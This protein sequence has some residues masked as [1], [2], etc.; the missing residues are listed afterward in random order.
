MAFFIGQWMFGFATICLLELLAPFVDLSFGSQYVFGPGVTLVLCLNFYFTGM[1]QAT[2]VF[3][4]SLGLFWYD[5]Y[6]SLVEAIINLVVSIILGY[7]FG[8]AG[9]FIGTLCSTVTTSLWVEPHMLYK[10]RLQAPVSVYFLKYAMYFGVTG[11]VWWLTDL[12]C[13]QVQGGVFGQF[14][15]RLLICLIVPNVM[16]LLVYGRSKEFVFVIRK[17]KRI[18]KSW[19]KRSNGKKGTAVSFS[20]EELAL[21]QIIRNSL[22][23]NSLDKTKLVLEEKEWDAV[24]RYAEKHGMVSLLYSELF[25][26]ADLSESLK[27]RVSKV[28]KQTV[29]QQ[30]RLLFLSKHLTDLLEENHICSVILKGVTVGTYYPVPELRKSGDVDLLLM[31][32]ADMEAAKKIFKENG[33]KVK[34]EQPSLHHICFSTLEGIEIELHTMLAEP[35]DNEKT[36]MALQELLKEA[37]GKVIKK[38]VMGVELPVLPDAYY[39]FD[40]LIHMLQHF[41]RSGFGLRLLCDWVMFWQKPMEKKDRKKY[42]ELV[43][44]IGIRGFSD[45]ITLTCVRFLGLQENLVHWMD[46]SDEYQVEAF[47][48]ETLDAEEFG[49]SNKKRMVVMRGTGFGDYVREFHHQMRLNYPKAGKCVLLWPVLWSATLV[50]FIR[51]NQKLRRI[52]TSS[53]LKEAKRR[54]KLI[55]DIRLF[56]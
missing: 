49:K 5:R 35:F 36:N 19:F 42:L 21:F 43:E 24:I 38:E 55:R 26:R 27:T 11:I 1:R 45:V 44:R 30:Y 3:R 50:K 22:F 28:A 13:K 34:E 41:L 29:L 47:M 16:F 12:C 56:K 6:K 48:R 14:V 17:A 37:E 8:T 53:I 31:N 15:V 4:D 7:Y 46:F 18:L 20:K 32:P 9:I 10:H 23:P 2:L 52:S 40:L 39:A 51:N 25:E 33:L 54:S